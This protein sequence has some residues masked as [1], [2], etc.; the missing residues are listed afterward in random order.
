MLPDYN[1]LVA[2]YA[3]NYESLA[4]LDT[5]GVYACLAPECCLGMDNTQWT[6]AIFV[7]FLLTQ[8]LLNGG[9]LPIIDTPCCPQG[10]GTITGVIPDGDDPT[11]DNITADTLTLGGAPS[12]AQIRRGTGTLAA[13]TATI[14]ATWVTATTRIVATY[15]TASAAG[16][17]NISIGTK[18]VGTSFVVN[19]EGTNTFDWIA[20]V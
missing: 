8:T 17:A 4:A 10:C 16:Q 1:T 3:A 15:T 18:T 5:D 2:T 19:G 20:V 14:A 11:F 12:I 9:V 13:G 7:Q 6:N